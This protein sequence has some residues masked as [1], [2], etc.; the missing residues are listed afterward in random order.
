MNCFDMRIETGLRQP[1]KKPQ[2]RRWVDDAPPF[3]LKRIKTGEEN[4]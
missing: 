4:G 2:G 3:L 1:G